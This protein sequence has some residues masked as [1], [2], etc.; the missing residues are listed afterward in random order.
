MEETVN[1]FANSYELWLYIKFDGRYS[2]IFD[3]PEGEYQP[4]EFIYERLKFL[5]TIWYFKFC[6]SVFITGR[7]PD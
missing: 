7:L 5:A 2:N 3:Q 6:I 1:L 4:N